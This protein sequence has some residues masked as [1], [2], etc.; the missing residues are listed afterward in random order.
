MCHKGQ[1]AASNIFEAV[2]FC[3]KLDELLKSVFNHYSHSTQKRDEL[4]ELSL[5]W[6][7]LDSTGNMLVLAL[8]TS[9]DLELE[10]IGGF[11][12]RS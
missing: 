4:E 9:F 7:P 10:Q 12:A 5:R 11:G 6:R 1:L 3:G 8:S 2:P